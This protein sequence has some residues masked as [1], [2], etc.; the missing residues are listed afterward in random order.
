MRTKPKDIKYCGVDAEKIRAAH[1]KVNE[2]ALE[3]YAKWIK[4]RYTVHLK[5]DVQKLPPPWTSW[6]VMQK[7]RF[8]NVR[9]EQDRESLF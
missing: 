1:P 4:E 5:K 9:R 8:C 3:L 6:D 2:L 7:Y